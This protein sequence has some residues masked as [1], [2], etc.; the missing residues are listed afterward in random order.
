MSDLKYQIDEEVYVIG[1]SIENKHI[2]SDIVIS[3]NGIKYKLDNKRHEY[4]QGSLISC[5]K[6]PN[7]YAINDKVDTKG[8]RLTDMTIKGIFITSSGIAYNVCD[9]ERLLTVS[10]FDVIRSKNTKYVKQPNMKKG[11]AIKVLVESDVGNLVDYGECTISAEHKLGKKEALT[12]VLP[13]G[14]EK[15]FNKND[16]KLAIIIKKDKWNDRRR[17]GFSRK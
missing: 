13:S 8:G 12:F 17:N 2:I 6:I 9:K 5:S 16:I 4:Q 14:I 10:H 11:D 3:R 1:T 15:T 7:H